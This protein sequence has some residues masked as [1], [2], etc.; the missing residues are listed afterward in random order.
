MSVT[1]AHRAGVR[2]CGFIHF[3]FEAKLRY[4]EG[5]LQNDGTDDQ[6]KLT[7]G[8]FHKRKAVL[9]RLTRVTQG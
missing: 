7:K 6:E 8:G 2:G 9:R 4:T 1:V 3:G 5:A